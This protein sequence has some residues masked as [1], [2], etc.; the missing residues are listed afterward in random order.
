MENETKIWIIWENERGSPKELD[1][2][3]LLSIDISVCFVGL[4]V[5]CMPILVAIQHQNN[6]WQAEVECMYCAQQDQLGLTL[7]AQ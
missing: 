1:R 3:E 2:F 7:S 5:H 6:G 4:S